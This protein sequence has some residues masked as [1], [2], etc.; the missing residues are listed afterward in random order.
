LILLKGCGFFDFEQLQDDGQFVAHAI[1]PLRSPSY[2]AEPFKVGFPTS[3]CEENWPTG[4]LAHWRHGFLLG[5]G[6]HRENDHFQSKD[7]VLQDISQIIMIV[8]IGRA[9]G[10]NT[11]SKSLLDLGLFP[12]NLSVMK[13]GRYLADLRNQR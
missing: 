1:F 7:G 12:N 9:A 5:N 6:C 4:P 3:V 13:R 8:N 10:K 11:E 2:V